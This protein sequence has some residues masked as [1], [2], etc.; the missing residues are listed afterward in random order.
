MC[1]FIYVYEAE[2]L[3]YYFQTNLQIQINFLF[4]CLRHDDKINIQFTQFAALQSHS[5]WQEQVNTN[6]HHPGL[7][8]CFGSFERTRC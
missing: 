3:I 4:T 2:G 6:M 7:H 5:S 8:F 1:N